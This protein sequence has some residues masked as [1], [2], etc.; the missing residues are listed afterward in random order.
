LKKRKM[1]EQGGKTEPFS[2]KRALFSQNNKKPKNNEF[3]K[4][5]GGKKGFLRVEKEGSVV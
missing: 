5:K 4:K 1:D 3:K 2:W